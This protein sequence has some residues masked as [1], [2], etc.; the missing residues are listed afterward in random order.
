[1]AARVSNSHRWCGVLLMLCLVGFCTAKHGRQCL[2]GSEVFV[3]ILLQFDYEA[4]QDVPQFNISSSATAVKIVVPPN[5]Q[6][7]RSSDVTRYIREYDSVL[8]RQLG[9]PKAIEIQDT[10][11]HTVEMPAEMLYADFSDNSIKSITVNPQL[12]YALRYLDLNDNYNLPVENITHFA[13]L[14]T[15]HLSLCRIETIPERLFASMTNLQHLNLAYNRLTTIDLI[16]FPTSLTLLFLNGNDLHTITLGG[17]IFPSLE[18]LDVVANRISSFNATLL[19]PLAPK[20]KLFSIA[21][22][23]L[24]HAMVDQIVE[25]LNRRNISHYDMENPD[26]WVCGDNEVIYEGIC[27]PRATLE[28]DETSWSTLGI[29]CSVMVVL[30]SL[31]GLGYVLWIR[32]KRN[33]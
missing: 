32:Y 4:G 21:H 30:A 20:L 29:V 13:Q 24:R 2:G 22:N 25:E 14:Q 33:Q 11:L 7:G 19:L 9:S 26:V 5:E 8:H 10:R 12:S 31:A 15:L 16:Q 27:F 3:C 23:P 6:L 28:S 1:M 18:H 17:A